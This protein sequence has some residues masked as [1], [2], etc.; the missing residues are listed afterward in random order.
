M[1]TASEPP[2]ITGGW[3]PRLMLSFLSMVMLLELLACS[4]IMLSI[5][6][7]EISR[8]FATSQGIWLM[9]SF[10]LVSTVASPLVG[11]LADTYGKRRM[12]LVSVVLS[13]GGSVVAALAP[14]FTVLL[15]GWSLVG[16]LS[17][18][19]FLVYSLIRDVYPTRTVPLAVSISTTGMGLIAIPAPVIAGHI[20]DSFGWRGV[21]WF[22]ALVLAVLTIGVRV[23]TEESPVRLSSRLDLIG[24]VLLAGGLTGI[25]IALSMGSDWGWTSA[26]TLLAAGLGLIGLVSWYIS[27]R[28]IADPLIKLDVLLERSVLFTTLSSGMCWAVVAT[29]TVMLPMMVMIP[30]EAGLGYGFG[31]SSGEYSWVQVP[32]GVCTLVAGFLVGGLVSRGV[33]SRVSMITGL[34]V[35]ALGC[36]GMAWDHNTLIIVTLWVSLVGLGTGMGYAATPNLLIESVPARLQAT[37]G[38]IASTSG[39]LFPAVL[40]VLVFAV[41]N[42]SYIAFESDG[43]PLYSDHG[44]TV[45]FALCAAAALLGLAAALALPIRRRPH[46]LDGP[47]VTVTKTPA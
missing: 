43:A 16:L 21:F 7:P 37:A 30:A 27:A 4:Y 13:T 38:G 24:S 42:N 22:C 32:M 2:P 35:T 1:S 45:G 20:I 41:L 11:K 46:I 26:K 40:P 5:A 23:T 47:L 3:T 19:I 9:T 29:F 10:L 25:L 39:N 31:L 36:A 12:L 8:E 6:L 15:A 17:P 14:T 33:R 18:C 28:V 34:A 44:I